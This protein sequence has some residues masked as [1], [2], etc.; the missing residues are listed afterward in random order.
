MCLIENYL[1]FIPLV[2]KEMTRLYCSLGIEDNELK[3][4]LRATVLTLLMQQRMKINEL[5]QCN[6]THKQQA[7]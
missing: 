6:E 1:S 2:V 3:I 7:F 4:L 5:S